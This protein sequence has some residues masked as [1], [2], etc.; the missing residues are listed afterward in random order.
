[1]DVLYDDRNES[2]GKKFSDADLIGIPLQII[3]GNSYKKSN[4][5]SIIVRKTKKEINVDSNKIV[6]FLMDMIT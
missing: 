5:L 6:N 2:P 3:C 1:M 4:Q